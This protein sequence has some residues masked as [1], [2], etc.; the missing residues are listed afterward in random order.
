MI[1]TNDIEVHNSEDIINDDIVATDVERFAEGGNGVD[2]N[3]FNDK[4]RGIPM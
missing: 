1:F 4:I 2:T 3:W